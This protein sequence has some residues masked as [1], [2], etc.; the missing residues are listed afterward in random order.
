MDLKSLISYMRVFE[1]INWRYNMG[2]QFLRANRRDVKEF[3]DKSHKAVSDIVKPTMNTWSSLWENRPSLSAAKRSGSRGSEP[4]DNE[5]AAEEDVLPP[6][7]TSALHSSLMTSGDAVVGDTVV[8][9]F[10]GH[11]V[12]EPDGTVR[13]YPSPV[14][15]S[16]APWCSVCSRHCWTPVVAVD[17]F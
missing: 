17:W 15:L 13:T 12:I 3:M 4:G 5:S 10:A 14:S 6:G 2:A 1:V 8:R 16:V 11:G 9:A 7:I